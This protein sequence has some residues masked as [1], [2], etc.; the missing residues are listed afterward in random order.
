MKRSIIKIDH[1]RCTGC[2]L[3][4]PG[5][6]EGAIQIIDGK[7]RLISDL[8][9]DGLGACLGHCPEGAISV[10]EREAEAYDEIKVMQNIIP[11][12]HN[13]IAA[14]L[15]H[16][17]AHGQQAYLKQAI[18]VLNDQKISVPEFRH[19]HPQP[20]HCPGSQPQ[21][22]SPVDSSP[23]SPSTPSPSQLRQWPVQL[24]LINPEAPYF[25]DAELLVAADCVPF[26]FGDFHQEF[27]KHRIVITFCPKLDSTLPEY[28]E[29][30]T[31]IFQNHSIRS[32]TVVIMEVPCCSG[33]LRLVQEAL[34]RSG[35]TIPIHR[36][37]ISLSGRILNRS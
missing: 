10:E 34:N 32:I 8:F 14:H 19:P 33:T 31:A 23:D 36:A 37:T 24:Q 20:H 28:L 9:C 25:S 16:L 4:I 26:A 15:Q 17:D 11:Q 21:Q 35:R 7:A 12:G 18:Q 6:P 13:V 5:C 3:C 22:F 30:L 27:L 29:K 2:G 1:K